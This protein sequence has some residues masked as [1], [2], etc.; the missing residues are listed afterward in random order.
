MPSTRAPR[1]SFSSSSS[2]KPLWRDIA[3]RKYSLQQAQDALEAGVQSFA[4]SHSDDRAPDAVSY[5]EALLLDDLTA[6]SL[7]QGSSTQVQR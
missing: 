3:S 7:G 2:E 4:G 5:R 6:W 1:S